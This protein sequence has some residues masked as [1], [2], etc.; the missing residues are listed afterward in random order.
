MAETKFRFI[1]Q[2]IYKIT[3]NSEAS[4]YQFIGYRNDLMAY[5]F[6]DLKYGR[7]AFH[8]NAE[9]VEFHEAEIVHMPDLKQFYI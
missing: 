5:A 9:S 7:R 6:N 4:L 8:L 3:I 2:E 1:P